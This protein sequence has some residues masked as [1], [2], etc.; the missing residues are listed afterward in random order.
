MT[1]TDRNYFVRVIVKPK[2]NT[3]E[4]VSDHVTMTTDDDHVRIPVLQNDVFKDKVDVCIQK[5][6][7]AVDEE[8]EVR[9][10]DV[11]P[12]LGMT[13][14]QALPPKAPDCLF[15][16]Y[17]PKLKVR[18]QVL[19]F[20]IYQPVCHLRHDGDGDDDDDDDVPHDYDYGSDGE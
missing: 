5:N 17:D 10:E 7:A 1:A 4:A 6:M 20:Y 8:A 16:Q 3:V 12:S 15:D 18:R 2:L 19:Q 9:F 14:V 13:S 11:A